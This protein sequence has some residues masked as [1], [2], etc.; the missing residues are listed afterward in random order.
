MQQ[1]YLLRY[2]RF[3]VRTA[4]FV[5]LIAEALASVAWAD[6]AAD[7][8]GRIEAKQRAFDERL[9]EYHG[10]VETMTRYSGDVDAAEVAARLQEDEMQAALDALQKV[11]KFIEEHPDTSVSADKERTSYGA[12]QEAY[13]GARR[14]LNEKRQQVAQATGDAAAI[15]AALQGHR[16]ELANLHRQLANVRFRKLQDE[17][18]QK[19]TVVVREELGCDDLTI[20][21]CKDGALERA[22]RSAV[23]QGSAVLLESET[24]MEEV[25]VFLGSGTEVQDHNVTRDWIASQVKGVLVGF[26]VLASGWVGESGY[27]YQIEAVVM[28]QV[29]REFFD[30]MGDEDLPALP[31]AEQNAGG[32]LTVQ[33]ERTTEHGVS[34]PFR[35]CRECPE[36]VVVPAG[37]FVMGSPAEEVERHAIGG[38]APHGHPVVPVG[39]RNLRGH[40][41]ESGM[42]A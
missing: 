35:D 13:A 33:P 16:E 17:L 34:A 5:F 24:V 40:V 9:A 8:Q 10:A 31:D 27:F 29:S 20:R 21:A 22:K 7:L 37:S 12:A 30:L 3:H 6:T 26:E 28:G 41:R 42:P 38:A 23:E 32:A 2:V 11:L 1:G 18:S 39:G 4:F 36:L 25:R 19:K 14:E 15:Y